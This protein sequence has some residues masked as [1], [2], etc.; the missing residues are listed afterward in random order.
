[1]IG[2]TRI[3]VVRIGRPDIPEADWAGL[4]FPERPHDLA[5]LRAIADAGIGCVFRY[6]LARRDGRVIGAAHGFLMRYPVA[7][8]LSIPVFAGGTPVNVGSPFYFSSPGVVDDV[9]PLLLDAMAAEAA[10]LRAKLLVV[11]D[12]WET[13]VWR[14]C[15]REL[16]SGGYR[17]TPMYLDALLPVRWPDYAGYLEWLPADRRKTVRRDT[18]RFERAG[19]RVETVTT[20]PADPTVAAMHRLWR[21]LFEKYRDRDQV[22][23]PEDY[24]RRVSALPQSTVLLALH[25]AEVVGFDLLVRRGAV[26]ESLYSGVDRERIGNTPVHRHL[27]GRI[28]RLAIEHGL[29]AVDFGIS[30]EEAKVKL[31]CELRLGWAYVRPLSRVARKLRLDRLVFPDEEPDIREE[32][33]PR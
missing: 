30:N 31:G 18:R 10:A 25:G 15:G 27:G 5:Y 11:R 32:A 29:E 19:F 33:E 3:T 12:L 26:L 17:R 9:L 16:F 20:Q 24:F 2:D 21:K 23:L 1:M 22:W 28:V 13:Q 6:F 4:W 7:G 8:P 14:T